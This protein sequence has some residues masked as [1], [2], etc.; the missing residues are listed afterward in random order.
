MLIKFHTEYTSITD[1]LENV[2]H[3]IS[4]PTVSLRD[5]TDKQKNY[6]DLSRAEMA[7]LQ[8]REHLKECEE[9]DYMM[10]SNLIHNRTSGIED[11]FDGSSPQDNSNRRMLRRETAIELPIT[12]SKSNQITVGGECI[13]NV[14]TNTSSAV[15]TATNLQATT[16]DDK[17][18]FPYPTVNN[19]NLSADQCINR[20]TST[21]NYL[22]PSMSDPQPKLYQK[23]NDSLQKNS[24]TDTEYSMLPYKVIKQ[25]STDTNTSLT[26][27]YNIDNTSFNCDLSMDT[28]NS[29]NITIIDNTVNVD[30]NKFMPSVSLASG[31]GGGTTNTQTPTSKT[32]TFG[33]IEIR[34][35]SMDGIRSAPVGLKKQFSI[36]HTIFSKNDDGKTLTYQKSC[37]KPSNIT[38]SPGLKLATAGLKESSSTSTDESRDD[39][40]IPVINTI[41]V[42]D[43]IAKLSSNI[44]NCSTEEQNDPSFNETMC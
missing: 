37:L 39:R 6:S 42:Q 18:E 21:V 14:T 8:E 13:T 9:N 15:T 28:E 12:P 29:P 17:D 11:S 4:S 41:V 25:N 43:E 26:G 31:V 40:S 3:M 20:K 1:E 36:D 30:N 32:T 33:S 23:S 10:L 5:S 27:S 24:S 38:N 35:A 22:I 19:R 2:C 34:Q 44:K 7:A 16:T